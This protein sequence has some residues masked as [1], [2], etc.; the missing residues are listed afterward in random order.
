[1][2]LFEGHFPY[3]N[4]HQA[5]LDWILHTIK[6]LQAQYIALHGELE[7]FEEWVRNYFSTL[8]LTPEVQ[9][10]MEEWYNDGR[11]ATLFNSD[12]IR[13][14]VS[15][16]VDMRADTSLAPGMF[17]ET[18]GFAAGGDGYSSLYVILAAPAYGVALANGCV[19]Y[20]VIRDR[21]V[22]LKVYDID[23]LSDIGPT[24]QEALT[25][26]DDVT[27]PP[28]NWAILTAVSTGGHDVRI[29]ADMDAYIDATV[30]SGFAIEINGGG[31][32]N[33][34]V[35]GGSW[36]YSTTDPTYQNG[37]AIALNALINF[38]D[39]VSASAHDIRCTHARNGRMFGFTRCKYV[40]GHDAY[41]A[42][43]NSFGFG[44]Q[45]GAV[46]CKFR[47]IEAENFNNP[48]IY[49]GNPQNWCYPIGSGVRTIGGNNHIPL[50]ETFI[51]ENVTVKDCSWEAFD[52]HNARAA[53]FRNCTVKNCNRF[54]GAYI[55]ENIKSPTNGSVLTVENCD[56]RCDDNFTM[57][58]WWAGVS[59]T[60]NNGYQYD[61]VYMRNCVFQGK[62]TTMSSFRYSDCVFESCRFDFM[63]S[64][65]TRLR[66]RDGSA[67][68]DHCVFANSH[69]SNG[70]V[71][72]ERSFLEIYDCRC[73]QDMSY[74]ILYVFN[75]D[76]NSVVR[77]DRQGACYYQSGGNNY[78]RGL[79]NTAPTGDG[80]YVD[81]GSL[82][83]GNNLAKITG[84]YDATAD[85][86]GSYGYG[87][88]TN[89]ANS[90]TFTIDT[91]AGSEVVTMPL[92]TYETTPLILLPGCVV[93]VDDGGTITRNMCLSRRTYL[94]ATYSPFIEFVF[95]VPFATAGTLSGSVVKASVTAF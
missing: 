7:G 64:G 87:I 4:F 71:Q 68:F 6:E 30:P 3:A 56:F 51:V 80:F 35:S 9:A 69:Y 63:K 27:I 20:P 34:E 41:I 15:A 36:T 61:K 18:G 81:G 2:G 12:F 65:S 90:R 78:A 31:I 76:E 57:I 43:C 13:R 62:P 67:R 23:G 24:L 46:S 79:V 11:L 85:G 94:D 32:Y 5:N 29:H 92:S 66:I 59:T 58:Q 39:C 45:D 33:G 52:T 28:G 17:V 75:R 49:N 44:V 47:N 88:F 89:A 95:A 91:N 53:T 48:Y 82:A 14:Y 8:D 1:M 72:I 60:S 10:V 21:K 25:W 86:F 37:S 22:N 54:F 16:D 73:E 74:P 19:A 26:A 50:I 38:T 40:T 93:D 84:T 83:Y 70:T 42:D 77:Y 55:E